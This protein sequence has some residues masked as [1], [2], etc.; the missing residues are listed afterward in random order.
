MPVSVVMTHASPGIPALS[1][2]LPILL[3]RQ[4]PFQQILREHTVE[5]GYNHVR[6]KAFGANH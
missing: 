5:A 1:L 4:S 2:L 6:G 3:T